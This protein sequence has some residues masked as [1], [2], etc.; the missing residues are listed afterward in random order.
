M[1]GCGDSVPPLS[2][3]GS[4]GPQSRLRVC[5]NALHRTLAG[6]NILHRMTGSVNKKR[7][8]PPC[9]RR[10]TR[11]RRRLRLTI[12]KHL[13]HNSPQVLTIVNA[14]SGGFGKNLPDQRAKKR[15]KQKNRGYVFR[16]LNPL[17]ALFSRISEYSGGIRT[18]L[19][20]FMRLCHL[21]A[22]FNKL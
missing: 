16:V 22:I 3:A 19:Q 13:F 20:L 12:T 2:A 11:T 10:H 7:K 21:F 15:R 8:N 1:C 9:G 4:G 17:F 6:E 18:R 14:E 5:M